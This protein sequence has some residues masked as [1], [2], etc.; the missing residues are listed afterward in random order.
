MVTLTW[1]ACKYKVHKLRSLLLYLCYVFQELINSLGL[2]LF[3]IYIYGISSSTDVV[4]YTNC[5]FLPWGKVKIG[6]GL[7]WSGQVPNALY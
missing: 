6:W 1:Q 3:Q 7:K 2:I 5:Q 4:M